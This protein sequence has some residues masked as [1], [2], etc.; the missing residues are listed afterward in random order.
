MNLLQGDAKHG[1]VCYAQKGLNGC[2]QLNSLGI[3]GCYGIGE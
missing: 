1:A 2:W 3:A